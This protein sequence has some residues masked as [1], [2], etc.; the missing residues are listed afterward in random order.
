PQAPRPPAL[1]SGV[2]SFSRPL[3]TRAGGS[4]LRGPGK[5]GEPEL[6]VIGATT[7]LPPACCFCPAHRPR[8]LVR[9]GCP[10]PGKSNGP[11]PDGVALHRNGASPPLPGRTLRSPC[12]CAGGE[13]GAAG[14]PAGAPGRAAPPADGAARVPGGAVIGRP[15]RTRPDAGRRA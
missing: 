7:T 4:R 5:D 1:N 2:S 13:D 15:A 12:R 11:G 9:G 8:R 10:G 6:T 3:P 14:P